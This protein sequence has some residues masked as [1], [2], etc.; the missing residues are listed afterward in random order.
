VIN[1]ASEKSVAINTNMALLHT[2][3]TACGLNPS[4]PQYFF[5]SIAEYDSVTVASQ[6]QHSTTDAPSALPMG[7]TSSDQRDADHPNAGP[8]KTERLREEA[9]L[10]AL[11]HKIARMEPLHNVYTKL[12]YNVENS[13]LM[14]DPHNEFKR[15]GVPN[16]NWRVSYA[17]VQYELCETYPAVLA[18]PK[19]VDDE[20]LIAAAP[21]RSKQRLPTLSWR[22]TVNNA[23]ISRSSQP[24]VGLGMSR[25]AADEFLLREISKASVL[26]SD[27]IAMSFSSVR[28]NTSMENFNNSSLSGLQMSEKS[29]ST[30]LSAIPMLPAPAR[31]YVITD[32]RPLLNARANQAAGKGVESDKNYENCSVVFLDIA[33]IHSMRKSLELMVEANNTDDVNW[34]RN[35]EAAGWLGHVRKVLLGA[36]KIAHFLS[37]EGLSVLV[38]C[39]DG[40]DRTSQLTSLS[41][42]MMDGYYRTLKGFIV[43]IEKEWLSFGHKFGDRQGWTSE[44]FVDEERSPIFAQF[45]DCV[46]QFLVQMPDAFEFNEE[47]LLF[48]VAHVYSGWFGN[49]LFN[50]EYEL[51]FHVSHKSLLSIWTVVLGN[52]EK[53]RNPRYTARESP[54]VPVVSKSKLVIWSGWF[55]GWYD[56]VWN[57]TWIETNQLD[58]KAEA[59]VID[60]KMCFKCEAAFTFT[61]R[62]HHC[63]CCGQ[64]F[65]YDCCHARRIVPAVSTSYEARCCNECALLLDMDYFTTENFGPERPAFG[66]GGNARASFSHKP[67]LA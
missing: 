5:H 14:Y 28:P 40:W 27:D 59:R 45:L 4:A 49:F 24:M 18:F 61:R 23:T 30:T 39:S 51:K 13:W 32:A 50:S 12:L 31:R 26:A 65:C 3:R 9:T 55:L 16:S 1:R 36:S 15:M 21:F 10:P 64:I 52:K 2:L 37:F 46:H 35:A 53:Y 41:M 17:N 56:K 60:G 11:V 38:H 29:A 58:V 7:W 19:S 48:L 22:S 54:V 47:L 57:A 67:L 43:L 25:N 63:R 44:G 34:L 66:G 42:L 33:N 20:S 62:K 6:R 8:S